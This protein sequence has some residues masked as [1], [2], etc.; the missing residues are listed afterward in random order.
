V[1]CGA[2]RTKV[3][4]PQLCP[5]LCEADVRNA[6]VDIRFFY[7]KRHPRCGVLCEAD[8]NAD[9]RFFYKIL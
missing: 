8:R 4:P 7:K 5:V 1:W 2:V 3:E 9:V 6:G